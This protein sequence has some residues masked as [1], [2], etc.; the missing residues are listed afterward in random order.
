[1]TDE[2]NNWMEKKGYYSKDMHGDYLLVDEG[3]RVVKPNEMMLVGYMLEYLRTRWKNYFI[4]GFSS[5]TN[6]NSLYNL[7]ARDIKNYNE[8]K[9]DWKEVNSIDDLYEG[10]GV[11]ESN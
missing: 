4:G 11:I 8:T 3:K 1:M 5:K 10:I 9:G 6:E 2:F 7:L